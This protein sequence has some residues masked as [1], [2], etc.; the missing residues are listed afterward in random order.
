MN[1]LKQQ[2][3]TNRRYVGKVYKSRVVMKEAVLELSANAFKLLNLIYH[4]AIK[5]EDLADDKAMNILGVSRRPY[6]KAKD[7]LQDLGYIRIVQVGSTKYLWYVGKTS[8]AKDADRYDK[9]KKKKADYEFAQLVLSIDMSDNVIC[10]SSNQA[11]S[12]VYVLEGFEQGSDNE[13]VICA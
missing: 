7:E 12:G 5:D 10:E 11:E 2:K 9:G 1:G 3:K 13:I 8:I 6:F 4:E